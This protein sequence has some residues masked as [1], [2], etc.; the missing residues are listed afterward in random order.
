MSIKLEHKYVF[1]SQF[2]PN[3]F[4]ISC[5]STA[6]LLRHNARSVLPTFDIPAAVRSCIY[7]SALHLPGSAQLLK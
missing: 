1:Q 2:E 6:L 5:K 4:Q 3:I 7:I